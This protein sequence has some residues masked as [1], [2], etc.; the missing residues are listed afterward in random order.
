M[1]KFF[2]FIA[3]LCC[4]VSIN[5]AVYNLR[6][7][8]TTITTDNCNDI[9]AAVEGVTGTVSYN[10]GTNTLSLSNA[11]L[12]TPD[13]TQAIW[14]LGIDGLTIEVTGLCD[15]NTPYCIALRLD[16]NTTIV[17]KSAD[18]LLKV[19]N[20]GPLDHQ[21]GSAAAGMCY[22]AL[23]TFDNASLTI[24]DCCVEAEG[25]G[26]ILLQGTSQLT[27]NHARLTALTI[28]TPTSDNQRKV[29]RSFKA[30][31]EPVLN[32]CEMILPEGVY[33][34]STLGGYT[35]DGV[36]ITREKVVI[37]KEAY[38]LWICGVRVT[39]DNCDDLTV[40]DGVW[41]GSYVRYN[42]ATNV[43]TLFLASITAPAGTYAIHSA[44]PNLTIAVYNP[45]Y[46]TGCDNYSAIRLDKSAEITG[47]GSNLTI[48]GKGNAMGIFLY[49]DY[50]T[51]L[52]EDIEL[53]IT[54]GVSVYVEGLAGI[55]GYGN[56][57]SLDKTYGAVLTVNS[58]KLTAAFNQYTDGLSTW[59]K[60][61][62]LEYLH[63]INLD[64]VNI[65]SPENTLIQPQQMSTVVDATTH[66]PVQ[67]IVIDWTPIADNGTL[68]GK[69]SIAENKQVQ[70]SQGNLQYKA[71]DDIWQFAPRQFDVLR[72][73]NE[74]ISPTYDGW[75]DLFGWGTGDNPTNASTTRSEYWSFT[76]WG[77]N[78]ISNGGN[79]KNVW[80]TI[81]ADHWQY[82]FV[83]RPNAASLFG[84]GQIEWYNENRAEYTYG[85]ILLPD[86]W[87]L[88]KEVN[89]ISSVEAGVVGNGSTTYT[90]ERTNLYED[91]KYNES[92]WHIMASNGAVFL[93]RGGYR[94]GTEF[95]SSYYGRYWLC[96]QQSNGTHLMSIESNKFERTK[97][98]AEFLG[99]SV[100][101]VK[102]YHS[103][104]TGIS[105]PYSSSHSGD[106]H[107]VLRDGQLLIIRG[108]KT[109]TVTGQEV[110]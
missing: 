106:T 74:N 86:N 71:S 94:N 66:N 87:T 63:A 35:T 29:M 88:P 61:G 17:G 60:G 38:D 56:Q 58:A 42:P 108:N 31:V 79:E 48:K 102:D 5:A 89:F 80:Y 11:T 96:S 32:N 39:S 57:Q 15:L 47:D 37:V 59:R 2:F 82:L 54:G 26:G 104:A 65:V 91:N 24:N 30:S 1:R 6:I 95:W 21:V 28:G 55:S 14:N 81:S 92:Q 105:E 10:P 78:A 101:L 53:S 19:H 52:T 18:A 4:A 67:N 44:I 98:T 40:I 85:I 70:F 13:V 50:N 20:A 75:I 107:K 8:G 62:A 76:D 110:K 23:T 7:C 46:V 109:Y 51:E 9:A 49:N 84:F 22:T 73:S 45:G 90:S 93:P 68:P 72:D 100:R 77:T 97:N 41:D 33:F 36:E 83:T 27:L 43:L 3:A 12:T 16:A 34:S 64:Y 25:A 103:P 69:F 99:Y